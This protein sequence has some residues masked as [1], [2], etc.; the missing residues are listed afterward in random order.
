MKA[1][2]HRAFRGTQALM[3]RATGCTLSGPSPAQA[4]PSEGLLPNYGSQRSVC[5]I[6]SGPATNVTNVTE[7]MI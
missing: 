4:Q 7:E 6:D 1:Y 3:G 5:V 2:A